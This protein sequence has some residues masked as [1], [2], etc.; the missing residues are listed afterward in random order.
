MRRAAVQTEVTPDTFVATEHSVR[1]VGH[2]SHE[3][4][5]WDM[6]LFHL[7]VGDNR[8]F[9]KT[10]GQQVPISKLCLVKNIPVSFIFFQ[11]FFG[12]L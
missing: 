8:R 2:S 9:M 1:L 5:T 6:K 4:E 3:G 10:R 7:L 11:R 12:H